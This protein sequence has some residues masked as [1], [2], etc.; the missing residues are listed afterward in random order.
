MRGGEADAVDATR[1]AFEL[2]DD[3]ARRD[4]P[5]HGDRV[6]AACREKSPWK[7]VAGNGLGRGRL[8]LAMRAES[9]ETATQA[10]SLEWP[11]A[12]VLMSRPPVLGA[13][14]SGFHSLT[15]RSAPHDTQCLQTATLHHHAFPCHHA[16]Y[17][18][19]HPLLTKPEASTATVRA[20]RPIADAA[21][22]APLAV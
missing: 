22:R 19:I 1:V 9:W 14:R 11:P 8:P 15:V 13:S 17:D 16:A 18:G 2:A 4:V 5:D 21:P 20:V 12:Y 6:A 10:T 7:T 3:L